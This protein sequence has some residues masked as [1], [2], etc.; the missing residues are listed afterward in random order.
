MVS[1]G[2]SWPGVSTL[3]KV[4]SVICNFWV[5]QCVKLSEQIHPCDTLTCCWDVKQPTNN[6]HLSVLSL[7]F[8]KTIPRR[9]QSCHRPGFQMFGVTPHTPK[10]SLVLL[11]ELALRKSARVVMRC[12]WWT[13]L[14]VLVI[15]LDW[16]GTGVGR[17]ESHLESLFVH[18]PSCEGATILGVAGVVFPH[19]LTYAHRSWWSI[20]HQRPP[21]IALCSGLLWSFWT[22]WFLAVSA[23]LRCLSPCVCVK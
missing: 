13:D 11:S 15:T 5:W 7:H 20:G 8:H 2:T 9:L 12:R 17:E 3:G 4:E 14:H 22:S 19:I 1:S 21:A 23:L 6:N 10:R 18:P 16:D